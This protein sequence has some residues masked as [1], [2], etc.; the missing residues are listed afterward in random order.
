MNARKAV[1]PMLKRALIS[2][3]IILP[4]L[5]FIDWASSPLVQSCLAEGTVGTELQQ[6][7]NSLI[8]H[9]CPYESGVVIEGLRFAASWSPQVWTAIAGMAIALFAVVLGCFTVSLATSTR[10]AA[11]AA[12]HMAKAAVAAERA[13]LYFIEGENNFMDYVRFAAS[14]SGPSEF[15]GRPAKGLPFA[16]FSFKNYGKTPAII[17]EIWFGLRFSREPF[18]FTYEPRKIEEH[19]ISAG[20]DTETITCVADEP[21]SIKETKDVRRG[22]S[23]LWLYG[24]VHYRDVFGAPQVHRFLRRF[25][26]LD[27]QRYGLRSYE[28]KDYNKS[29]YESP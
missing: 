1:I 24:K 8:E 13:R 5:A 20:G 4:I 14:W 21:L 29:T 19:M 3:L 2:A 27:G 22:E 9:R 10:I 12:T 23:Y 18:D 16:K 25:V 6:I 26:R 7:Y 11:D 15:E 17:Q 28:Y